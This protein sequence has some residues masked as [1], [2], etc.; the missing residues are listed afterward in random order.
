MPTVIFPQSCL[1]FPGAPKGRKFSPFPHPR[2]SLSNF[3]SDAPD[4]HFPPRMEVKPLSLFALR[5]SSIKK[6][7][8]D[9]LFYFDRE[10]ETPSFFSLPRNGRNAVPPS[11]S[12]AAFFSLHHPFLQSP[13]GSVSGD[14]PR[15][16]QRAPSMIAFSFGAKAVF[17]PGTLFFFFPF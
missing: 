11:N 8:I 15:M 6:A 13:G 16:S 3:P 5:S 2:W 10:T 4:F 14:H 12:N 7:N 1:P 9:G 17:S